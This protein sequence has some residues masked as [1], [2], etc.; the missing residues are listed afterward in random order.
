MLAATLIAGAAGVAVA[1]DATTYDPGQLPA[2]QGKVTQYSLTS[3]GDV[4]GIMANMGR[5]TSALIVAK[6]L[7]CLPHGVVYDAIKRHEALQA[8]RAI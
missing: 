6:R 3:R 8:V 1:H 2:I 7:Q 5:W 4:D